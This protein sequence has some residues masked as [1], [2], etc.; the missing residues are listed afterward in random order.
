MQPQKQIPYKKY[1]SSW[2]MLP[3]EIFLY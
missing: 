2:C 1:N 3:D